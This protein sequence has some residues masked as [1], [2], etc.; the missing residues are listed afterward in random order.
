MSTMVTAPSLPSFL[1]GDTSKP[2][3]TATNSVVKETAAMSSKND[4][5]GKRSRAGVKESARLQCPHCEHPAMRRNSL[6][7]TVLT[8]QAMYYCTNPECGHTFVTLTEIVRTL[9]PSAT[10]NPSVV[11]PLSDHARR[12]LMRATLDHASVAAHETQFTKPVTGDLF[13]ERPSTD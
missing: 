3:D 1:G 8:H 12:D 4:S 9:S 5:R 10:P 7:I 11:L 2:A 6:K 13:N